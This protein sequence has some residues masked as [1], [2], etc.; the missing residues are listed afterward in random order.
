M[1]PPVI[2]PFSQ[3]RAHAR[4]LSSRCNSLS[5]ARLQVSALEFTHYLELYLW[6][7]FE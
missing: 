5:V 1:F 6:P 2:P 3:H 4:Y 7:N